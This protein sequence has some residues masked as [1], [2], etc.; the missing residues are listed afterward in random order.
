MLAEFEKVLAKLNV[1]TRVGD[2]AMCFCPAHDDRNR[3]SLSV[4]AED[5]KLLMHCFAGCRPEDVIAVV[6]L[7]WHD[8]FMEGGGAASIPRRTHA[9]LHT[10]GEKPHGKAENERA[11][12]DAYEEHGCTLEEYAAVE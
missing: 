8:F 9:R 2:K 3:P 5:G 12:S 11:V 1:A 7:E 10:Q 6:G 4:K